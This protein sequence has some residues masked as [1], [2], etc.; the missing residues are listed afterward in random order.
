MSAISTQGVQ[1]LRGETEDTLKD[2][3]WISEYPDLIE[4]PDTIDVTTLMHKMQA[5]IPALPTSSARAFPAFV[6]EDAANLKA[7]QDTA[8]TPA[9]YAVRS[10]KGWGWTW[11]GQHSVSVPGKGVD[12][13]IQ[14]NIVITNDSDVTFK[15]NITVTE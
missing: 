4:D 11:H 5:N 13:A 7:V 10:R 1:L 8:D 12:D 9:Y 2:L 6:D 14:F 3:C 15:E